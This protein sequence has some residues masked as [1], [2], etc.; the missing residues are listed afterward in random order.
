MDKLVYTV[1]NTA[2]PRQILQAVLSV[3]S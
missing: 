1:R 3:F 2:K